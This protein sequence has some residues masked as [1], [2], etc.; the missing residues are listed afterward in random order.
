[1]GRKRVPR[2]SNESNIG[3]GIFAILSFTAVSGTRMFGE[4]GVMTVSS[5][6]F[7]LCHSGLTSTPPILSGI[8]GAIAGTAMMRGA[9]WPLLRSRCSPIT[10]AKTMD[11]Q[12]KQYTIRVSET[13]PNYYEAEIRKTDGGKL[14]DASGLDCDFI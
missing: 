14:K 9:P 4:T 8:D 5:C 6:T 2:R 13:R 3:N 12:Y 10:R 11:V 1:M 7:P